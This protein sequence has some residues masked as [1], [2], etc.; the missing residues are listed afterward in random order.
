MD[1]FTWLASIGPGN[2]GA[3]TLVTIFIILVFT[4]RIVPSST[5]QRML[6][7]RETQVQDWKD[8]FLASE[9]ARL[10]QD[11]Q[12]GE[13]L[14]HSRTTIRLIEALQRVRDGS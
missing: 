3:A 9:Q 13:L 1:I 2:I 11:K 10:E 5:V 14:E 6:N 7:F 4:G 8:A 12:I